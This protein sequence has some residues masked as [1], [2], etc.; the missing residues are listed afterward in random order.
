MADGSG[1]LRLS[2]PAKMEPFTRPSRHKVAHGGRGGGKSH[3]IAK[4]L[5]IEGCRR[6]LRW[7]CTREIQKSIKDSV[8]KL[9]ADQIAA[10]NLGAFYDVQATT[11][12]A[13]NGG[14]FLFAGLQ[15]HTVESIKSFEGCDGAWIEEAHSVSKRSDSLLAASRTISTTYSRSSPGTLNSSTNGR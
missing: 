5:L 10:M 9:L 6:P 8:H 1:A 12:R 11:I 14:E 13:A 7:L 4:L 15:D 2:L 3:T